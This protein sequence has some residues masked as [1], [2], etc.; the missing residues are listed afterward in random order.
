MHSRV[1]ILT[2]AGASTALGRDKPLA[3]MSE[4]ATSLVEELGYAAEL[5]GLTP[6]MDGDRFEAALGRFLRFAEALPTVEPLHKLGGMQSLIGDGT[7]VQT[8]LDSRAW[9]NFATQ[10][11]NAIRRVVWQNLYE[12]FTMDRVDEEKAYRSYK[13]LH[14]LIRNSLRRDD[15]D[16]IFLVHATT[17]F[18]RAIE[19]A[20][21]L[22]SERVNA[23]IVSKDGF[24]S[25]FAGRR[26]QWAPNTLESA[27]HDGIIP[28]L[29][30]H[31][32]VGWYFTEDGTI[33]SRP[34]DEKIDDRLTPALL[35]PDDTKSVPGFPLPCRRCGPH[36]GD[37]SRIVLM[38]L[39][40]AIACTMRTW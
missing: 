9:L 5:L 28:V 26:P 13:R 21:D 4:W 8:V 7:Q 3:M 32:A 12:Q 30:L 27:D 38:C 19:A 15:Q 11:V 2:G 39:C 22:E 18:D 23:N 17:N 31:G 10:N 36:S 20:I 33:Q 14:D 34:S 1:M 24:I 29:H 40:S 6:S 25:T 16:P 35:L 37:N